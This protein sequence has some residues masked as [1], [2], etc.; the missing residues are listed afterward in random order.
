MNVRLTK[1]DKLSS[2]NKDSLLVQLI[3]F[4]IGPIIGIIISMITVPITT[5]FLSPTELGKTSLFSLFQSVILLIEILGLDQSY[6]RFYN[7]KSIEEEKLLNHCIFLPILISLFISVFILVFQNSISIW[8]FG[9]IEK[10]LMLLISV[11][12]PI[13]VINRFTF[14][15]IRMELKG[16]TYSFLQLFSKITDF[17]FLLLLLFFYQT[18]FR[19]IVYTLIVS[20]IC[21]TVLSCFFVNKKVFIHMFSFKNLDK[22]LLHDILVFGLPLVPAT[23]LSWVLNSFDKIGLRQWS[24]FTELGL[25]TAAFK[26]VSILSVLQSI[27]TTTYVPVAYKW[28][29]DKVTNTLFTKINNIVLCTASLAFT[30]IIIFRKLI[31]LFL[32]SEYRG[33]DSIFVFLIFVPIMYTISQCTMLGITFSKKTVYN[34]LIFIISALINIGGNYLLIPKMG[35]QG[36]ALTTCVSYVVYFII[37]TLISRHLWYKYPLK[38]YFG[39]ILL[40]LLL[41]FSVFLNFGFIIELI[42][43]ILI[44]TYSIVIIFPYYKQYKEKKRL[45]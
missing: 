22:K 19:S 2:S 40:L 28:Y 45:R 25:Y 1:Q 44:V 5:N 43:T 27:F 12:L 36:A 21:T 20:N 7:N 39:M 34:L 38:N 3:N 11:Y 18:T 41:S 37:G 4:G 32:G 15:Q 8:L 35:A 16:K 33:T 9:S 30:G 10:N 17:L 31:Y 42:I 13:L 14:L 23:I 26:I 29:E 24:T 6:T